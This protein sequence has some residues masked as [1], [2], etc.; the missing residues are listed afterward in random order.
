MKKIMMRKIKKIININHIL[1]LTLKTIK[2]IF[3]IY[4]KW[5][6]TVIKASVLLG[7]K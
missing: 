5:L 7:L 6:I 3:C 2:N 1:K 4:E